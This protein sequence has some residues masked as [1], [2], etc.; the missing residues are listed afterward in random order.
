MNKKL[1]LRRGFSLVEL[2]VVVAIMGTLAAI[3]IP[4][5]NEYRKAAKK[6]AYK[7]DLIGLHK[8]VLA[9]GVELDSYCERETTPDDFSIPNVGMRSLLSSKLYGDNN[10]AVNANC[11]VGGVPTP[12]NLTPGGCS[13]S[14][15]T[16]P[17]TACSTG[18][19]SAFVPA[20]NGPDKDNFMGFEDAHSNCANITATNDNVHRLRDGSGTMP[21]ACDLNVVSYRLGAAGHISGNDFIGYDIDHEGVVNESDP[22]SP[23][24][25]NVITA[26]CT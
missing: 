20:G 6:T 24:Y 9:F 14:G 10:V 5:Y 17:C 1:K 8:G 25:A 15:G 26:M 16:N 2:M 13:A 23:T 4:A 3:A 11:D 22:A 21:T 18:T 12:A 7:T 19:F